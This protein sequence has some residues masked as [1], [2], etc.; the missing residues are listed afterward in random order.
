MEKD[1][2]YI[3]REVN[4]K[5]SLKTTH[6]IIIDILKDKTNKSQLWYRVYEDNGD[7]SLWDEK[8]LEFVDQKSNRKETYEEKVN[9]VMNLCCF[10]KEDSETI[11]NL[12][13]KYLDGCGY[14]EGDYNIHGFERPKDWINYGDRDFGTWLLDMA[15][16]YNMEQGVEYRCQFIR[17]RRNEIL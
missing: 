10:D 9:H 12:V 17:D 14:F 1:Y 6:G 2:D 7:V 15:L 4:I 13:Y 11:I 16:Q 5:G 8:E 3:G